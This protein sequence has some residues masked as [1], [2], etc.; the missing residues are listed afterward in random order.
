MKCY[1]NIV[2]AGNL[3]IDSLGPSKDTPSYLSDQLDFSNLKNLV[4]VTTCFLSDKGSLIDIALTN[5]PRSFHKAQR[6]VTSIS[7]FH[8]LVVTVLRYCYKKL[9]SK[10]ILY[11]NVKRFKKSTLLRDLDSWLIQGELYNN[12]QEPY[13]N[14]MQIFSEILDYHAPVKQKA[15]RGNQTPFK[16]RF[17]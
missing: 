8:K 3:N 15:V 17:R 1:D 12:C 2:L 7:N 4:K 6:F 5:K 13:N 14:L 11:R 10:N 16:K 9:P